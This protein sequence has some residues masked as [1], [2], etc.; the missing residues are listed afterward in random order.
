MWFFSLTDDLG[1]ESAGRG[2]VGH[3]RDHRLPDGSTSQVDQLL[4]VPRLENDAVSQ[5]EVRN[6]GRGEQLP[7]PHATHHQGPRPVRLRQ[8]Q[9]HIEEL[10]GRDRRLH[11]TLRS[12][13]SS[14][15]T[16]RWPG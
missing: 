13:S 4:V 1:A 8:L 14:T 7:D 16:N 15:G 12:V 3:G 11:P 5:Q 6:S 9:V 2:A 10:A